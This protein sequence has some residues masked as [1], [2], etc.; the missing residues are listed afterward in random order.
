[1]RGDR[2]RDEVFD[3]RETKG[4]YRSGHQCVATTTMWNNYNIVT[5]ESIASQWLAIPR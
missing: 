4:S 2:C 3:V 1:M 5:G